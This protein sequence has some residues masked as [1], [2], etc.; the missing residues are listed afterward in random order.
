MLSRMEQLRTP[1]EIGFSDLSIGGCSVGLAPTRTCEQLVEAYLELI[2]LVRR[3]TPESL[4]D[5]DITVLVAECNMDPEFLRNRVVS[6]LASLD[7]PA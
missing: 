3:D 1:L 7:I 2:A 4:R 5:E 6:H